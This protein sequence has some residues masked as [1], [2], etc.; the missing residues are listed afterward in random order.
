MSAK[1]AARGRVAASAPEDGHRPAGPERRKKGDAEVAPSSAGVADE[2]SATRPGGA[3][4]HG[5][6]GT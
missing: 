6:N 2:A 5:G 3:V 1:C 4:V